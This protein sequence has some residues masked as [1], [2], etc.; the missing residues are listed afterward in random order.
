[1]TSKSKGSGTSSGGLEHVDSCHL[2]HLQE[3][4]IRTSS[5]QHPA[6]TKDLASALSVF[7]GNIPE[8]T[9][10]EIFS[11]HYDVNYGLW[12]LEDGLKNWV[13]DELKELSR[14]LSL[15]RME[16]VKKNVKINVSWRDRNGV[17]EF[18]GKVRDLLSIEGSLSHQITL[19][20]SND[21]LP[22][23]SRSFSTASVDQQ[24]ENASMEGRAQME[25]ESVGEQAR[26]KWSVTKRLKRFFSS[27]SP[28]RKR[29]VDRLR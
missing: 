11:L 26:V 2:I 19:N 27:S 10:F 21:C 12:D 20:I 4:N 7:I 22:L 1:M 16:Y 5:T 24:P 29:V 14:M 9:P 23:D 17:A 28:F 8:T 6:M 13:F 18:Q 3:L 15:P 25:S